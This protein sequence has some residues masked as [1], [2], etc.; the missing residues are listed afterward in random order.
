MIRCGKYG[1][2][3][4]CESIG[5]KYGIIVWDK[6]MRDTTYSIIKASLASDDTVTEAERTVLLQY[7][8]H[9]APVVRLPETPPCMEFLTSEEAAA[10]LQVNCRTVQ[11]W[12]S[13]GKLPSRRIMGCRR[14]LSTDFLQ[15]VE[16]VQAVQ[17]FHPDPTGQADDHRR[18]FTSGINDGRNV[19]KKA[20]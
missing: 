10:K 4:P 3:A 16:T 13:S 17:S 19:I 15:F 18:I 12:M 14:I 1:C 6:K 7:C 11:R 5:Q 9:P 2:V 20:S 8:R